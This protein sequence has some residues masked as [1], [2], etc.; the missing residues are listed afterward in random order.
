MSYKRIQEIPFPWD[1][2][3]LQKLPLFMREDIY[4]QLD[5]FIEEEK[6]LRQQMQNMTR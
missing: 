3:D 5:E 2:E 1:F 4:K 6:K